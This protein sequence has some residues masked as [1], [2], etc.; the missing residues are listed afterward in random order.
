MKNNLKKLLKNKMNRNIYKMLKILMYIK[1][2]NI[3][4]WKI[5]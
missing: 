5:T 3:F 1:F 4:F 2:F